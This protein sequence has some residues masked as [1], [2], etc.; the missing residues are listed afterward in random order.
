MGGIIMLAVLINGAATIVGALLGLLLKKGISEAMT[1]ALFSGIS[2]CVIVMGVQGAIKTENL[3]LLLFSM[4]VGTCIGTALAI[5][6]HM[7][8]L[9]E[10]LKKRFHA[11]EDQLFLKGFITLSVMQVI[12]SMAILGPI[13]AALAGDA[14]ILYFKSLLDF[15]AAFIFGSIYGIGVVPVGIV[16]AAYEMFFYL[17]ASVISPLMTPDVIR[18]LNAVGNVMI[19]AIGLNMLGVVKLKVAD[20]LPALFI[21]VIYYFIIRTLG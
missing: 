17:I 4:A 2:L 1:K 21:P 19:L 13:Q 20:Y 3:M 12:G 18:E 9:G 6:D 15:M 7:Q 8:L 16:V 5:E 10:Y 11:G 14:S